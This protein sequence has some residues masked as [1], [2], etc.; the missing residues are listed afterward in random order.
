MGIREEK[1]TGTKGISVRGTKGSFQHVAIQK[2]SIDP[3]DGIS[4][5]EG[6]KTGRANITKRRVICASSFAPADRT[7]SDEPRLKAICPWGNHPKKGRETNHG[8]K[9][10]GTLRGKKKK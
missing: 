1:P 6:G 10:P 4:R 5:E 7:S 2:P 9:K 8:A 3:T